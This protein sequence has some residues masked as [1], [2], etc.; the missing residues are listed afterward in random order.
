MRRAGHDPAHSRDPLDT[1]DYSRESSRMSSIRLYVLASL[2]ERGQLGA[3]PPDRLALERGMLDDVGEEL[4]QRRD[5]KPENH[6]F[7]AKVV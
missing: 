5:F 3:D 7:V 6:S 4:E 1:R 2:A